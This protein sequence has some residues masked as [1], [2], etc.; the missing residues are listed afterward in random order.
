MNK[1]LF[2]VI[3]SDTE[4]GYD[5]YPVGVFESE[6]EASGAIQHDPNAQ[7]DEYGSY[8]E[9]CEVPFGRLGKLADDE[10]IGPD[11]QVSKRRVL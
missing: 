3:Y 8:F 10:A 1:R 5:K 9:I 4:Y 7:E 6:E 2:V 11:G